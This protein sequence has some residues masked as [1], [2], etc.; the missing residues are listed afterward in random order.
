MKLTERVLA[1]D[2]RAVSRLIRNIEDR[3]PEAREAIKE[4]F[5]HTGRAHVVGLTGAPGAGKST[6]SDALIASYRQAEM[7]IG[8]LAVDPTSPFT[9]G[10]ILGDR[11]RMQRHAEDPGVFIRSL[12]T[13]GA[14]GGLS[15]AV[16][17]A[18]LVLDAMGKDVVLVETVGTGQSE[19]D[20]I[21]NAQTV[22]LILTPGM[23]DDVQTIKAGVMEIADI[24]VI[25]KAD[26]PGAAKLYNDLVRTLEMAEFGQDEWRPPILKIGNIAN[27][28]LFA[29]QIEVLRAKIDTHLE[30]LK[31]KDQLAGLRLRKAKMAFHKALKVTLLDPV[32]EQ[33]DKTGQLSQILEQIRDKLKDPYTLAEEIGQ[34]LKLNL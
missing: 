15:E 1:G 11:I 7:S 24:F 31:A 19:V 6:L 2:V 18:I 30:F 21:N 34:E 3:L 32:L 25:N 16:D 17:D 9:G 33:L 13:R 28:A 23:G 14:L 8:V 26:Q 29:E 10:A 4:L 5:S 20:I 22:V 12:A 27:Q